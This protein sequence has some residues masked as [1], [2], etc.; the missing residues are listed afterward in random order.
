MK[1]ILINSSFIC[2]IF[3]IILSGCNP[4]IV[5]PNACFDYIPTINLITSDTIRF[6]NSSENATRY[7]WDFGD[8][9]KSTENSPKHI[10]NSAG[11]YNVKLTTYN[12]DNIDSISKTIM[13]ADTVSL[14]NLIIFAG[15]GCNL[16]VDGDGIND[17][18]I[19]PNGFAGKSYR[20]VYSEITCFNGYEIFSDSIDVTT[21]HINYPDY[22]ETKTSTKKY[23]P[24]IYVI[25]DKIINSDKTHYQKLNICSY[26]TEM[27]ISSTYNNT[28]I[29]DEVRYIG[30]RKKV[31]NNT[32]IGWIKLKV[33]DYS[34]I[35]LY[36]YKIPSETESL[37]LDK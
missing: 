21:T 16:D 31:G 4:E 3:T 11:S 1:K 10:Y 9:I 37:L 28:W 30:F 6:S 8:G 29:K 14:N 34:D 24:K 23:I 26:Y 7:L 33:N 25:G 2:F 12:E 17:I 19:F 36:S 15:S 27:M 18:N 22:I 32:K 20:Y 13:I 35:T 5:K